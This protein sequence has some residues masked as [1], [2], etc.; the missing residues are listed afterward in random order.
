LSRERIWWAIEHTQRILTVATRDRDLN[1]RKALAPLAV[2]TRISTVR[3]GAGCLTVVTPNAEIG[4]DQ[5]NI[6]SIG[7]S[8]THHKL[9]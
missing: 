3:C 7:Q 5:Q 4:I 1:S 9:K 8:L 6:L 2:K